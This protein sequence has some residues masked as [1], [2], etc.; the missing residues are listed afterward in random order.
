MPFGLTCHLDV[1]CSGHT[2][3]SQS[4]GI[5]ADFVGGIM[6]TMGAYFLE[7][8]PQSIPGDGWT[9]S[10]RFSRRGDYRQPADVPTVTMQ[11]HIVRP[12]MRATEAAILVWAREFVT[13]SDEVLE[14]SLR[15]VKNER[16]NR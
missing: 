1:A 7:V 4:Q 10:V 6:Y 9:G 16:A 11:S 3:C 8:F 13:S 15:I 12:T 2:P 14:S 5:D